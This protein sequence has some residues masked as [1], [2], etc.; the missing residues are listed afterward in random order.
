MVDNNN[1]VINTRKIEYSIDSVVRCFICKLSNQ[2]QQIIQE[3]VYPLKLFWTDVLI[4]NP[5]IYFNEMVDSNQEIISYCDSNVCQYYLYFDR[6]KYLTKLKSLM[7]DCMSMQK[8]MSLI[9]NKNNLNKNNLNKNDSNNNDNKIFVLNDYLKDLTLLEEITINVNRVISFNIYSYLINKK[10]QLK[11]IIFIFTTPLYWQLLEE[12]FSKNNEEQWN[13]AFV[14]YKT[15]IHFI[16]NDKYSKKDEYKHS[17]VYSDF[18]QYCMDKH[19]I[20][21]ETSGNKN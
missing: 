9:Y 2:Q 13:N 10:N 1:F 20:F 5:H 4:N 15:S 17:N 11:K 12:L 3:S 7:I 6:L 19:I 21:E 14:P 8:H 16:F 18:K